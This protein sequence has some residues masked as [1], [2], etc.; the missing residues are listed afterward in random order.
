MNQI[1][2][3]S[4][5]SILSQYNP[6][7]SLK[8]STRKKVND[9]FINPL[10]T[11]FFFDKGGIELYEELDPDKLIT[12]VEFVTVENFVK[13]YIYRE[14]INDIKK[15]GNEIIFKPRFLICYDSDLTNYQ[16]ENNVKY[17][18]IRL[19]EI[20]ILYYIYID[21]QAV[22]R[23]IKSLPLDT[24]DYEIPDKIYETEIEK[25]NRLFETVIFQKSQLLDQTENL[26]IRGEIKREIS[27]LKT[28]KSQI[29]EGNGGKLR[30]NL[31]WNTTDDLDLHIITPNGE[32]AYNTPNRTLEYKGVFA[33][34]DVDKN[35][36]TDIVSNPQ[37]N[38]NFDALPFGLHKIYVK[39]YTQREKDEVPF[40]ITIIPEFGE[41]RIY[42]RSI[43]GKGSIVDVAKFEQVNGVLEIQELV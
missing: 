33:I 24:T 43:K 2:H 18:V 4:P 21:L 37:E 14:I 28:N 1:K 5:S 40:I 9:L 13:T 16:E 12:E 26:Q 25:R 34:L 17:G 20:P 39:F 31:S 29:F 42:S 22:I 27:T 35:A 3:N 6:V 19:G 36:G 41:G 7:A 10:L 32:I 8:P 15:V 23:F 30:V 11:A 38:I